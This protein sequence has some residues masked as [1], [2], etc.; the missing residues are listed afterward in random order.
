MATPQVAAPEERYGTPRDKPAG[1][2]VVTGDETVKLAR[3]P[4]TIGRVVA[5]LPR[6][7]DA[8]DGD[9]EGGE[10]T[11]FMIEEVPWATHIDGYPV[12]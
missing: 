5:L 2:P 9:V 6:R 10:E 1:T 11:R 12:G 3:I 8:G 4:T 7:S